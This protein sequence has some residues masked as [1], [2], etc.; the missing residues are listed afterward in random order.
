MRLNL[1]RL[2]IVCLVLALFAGD[3]FAGGCGGERRGPVRA[4]L[5]GLADRAQDR[6]ATRTAPACAPAPQ[7]SSIAPT[8]AAV[9][10]GTTGHA[11]PA[12]SCSD[13]RCPLPR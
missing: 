4:L 3:L 2:V 13:G 12:Q 8:V 9:A 6:R 1:I 11:A 10:Y 5:G 7:R